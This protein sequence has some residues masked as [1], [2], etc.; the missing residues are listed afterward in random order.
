MRQ[1]RIVYILMA[2]VAVGLVLQARAAQSQSKSLQQLGGI[3]DALGSIAASV[4]PAVV[5]IVASGYVPGSPG[6]G[7]MGELL[8]LQRSGGSGV[9]L[10]PNGYV[11]TNA[12]V[13]RGSRQ[14]QVMLPIAPDPSHQWHSILRPLGKVYG[15]QLVGL[16]EETD[17]AVLKVEG[18]GLPYLTLGD[19]DEL[20]PGQIVLAF[21]SPLGL[22][23]S[24]TLGVVS[25]VARQM[26]P[27]DP[28]IYIQ[29]DAPINPGNSGGPLI[30]GKGRVVGINTSILSRSGG[31]EGLGFAAPSNIVRAVYEQIKATGRVRRGAIGAATQTVTPLLAEALGLPQQWGVIVSDVDPDSPAE[32]DGLRAGDLIHSLD[33]KIMENA[34]QFTVNLYQRAVGDMIQ[35]ELI[36]DGQPLRLAT[37]V[38]ERPGD[39]GRFAVYVTPERNLIA[40]LGILALDLDRPIASMLPP[41]RN[42]WGIVVA[43]Q[44]R[45][46]ALWESGF[47][48][49]DVIYTLNGAEVEDLAA[50]RRALQPIPAGTPVAVGVERD[51]RLIYVALRSE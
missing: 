20:R 17:L 19:S 46:T 25:A 3:N 4:S 9:I 28:M 30:D 39:P 16:D 41:L 48:P 51:S 12:H 21:G 27:E 45:E 22:D 23:N 5:Q 33:G 26:S 24:V 29:T 38:I 35:L 37:S 32:R 8:S 1:R 10:D 31:S 18:K 43:A 15:A 14:V 2:L 7:A 40:Q 49:G 6:G 47:L 11:V 34:R 42:E 36:R 13:V 50:L 44:S